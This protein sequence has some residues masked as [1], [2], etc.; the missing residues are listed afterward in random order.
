MCEYCC[1]HQI[2]GAV[3]W[4]VTRR[5]CGMVCHQVTRQLGEA[6][7]YRDVI[8]LCYYVPRAD[9]AM[10]RRLRQGGVPVRVTSDPPS[11]DDVEELALAATDV[12]MVTD[13]QYVPGLER[14]VVMVLGPGVRSGWSLEAPS[15]C[16]GC[17][18]TIDCD[19]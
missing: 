6:L 1:M 3:A 18:Y 8:I 2:G 17:L 4:C 12:V 11:P 7:Q 19:P 14:R 16:S 10:V 13:R 15:R 5:C 9:V